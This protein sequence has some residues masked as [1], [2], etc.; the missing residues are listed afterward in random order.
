MFRRRAGSGRR[1][2]KSTSALFTACMSA[3]IVSINPRP[4]HVLEF[5]AGQPDV[6]LQAGQD[7]GD[8]C[9]RVERQRLLGAPAFLAQ[10][11][12]RGHGRRVLEVD[13]D[14]ARADHGHDPVENRLVEVDAAEPLYPLRA[15]DLLKAVLGL[16]QDRRLEGA[17][18]EVVDG[19]HGPGRHALLAG[20][21]NG[22][23]L[24]LGKQRR[25]GDARL[26]DGL[27]EEVD[28]VG[29]VAGG[30]GDD[31]GHRRFAQ[32]LGDATHDG[33]Q[34]VRHKGLC[35]VRRPT[36]DDRHRVAEPPLELARRSGRLCERATLR[37]VAGE[38][39]AVGPNDDDRR[40]GRRTLAELEDL[41]AALARG[42]SG[43][44]GR[45]Q[46]DPKRVLDRYRRRSMQVI[47]A[48]GAERLSGRIAMCRTWGRRSHLPR[49]A[50]PAGAARD[51]HVRQYVRLTGFDVPQFGH[52]ISSA[53]R[54]PV[55][56]I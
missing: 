19:D 34:L 20:V 23:R 33:P 28:L 55:R 24:R 40:N 21:L 53:M 5:L 48:V 54:W 26:A 3:Q 10:A 9:V 7:D 30:M 41:D 14:P 22:G 15:A 16:A 36:D 47:S 46:V 49:D 17:A 4:D 11:R 44:V 6:G 35:A 32:F 29:A 37:G 52:G 56:R 38:D 8:R 50:R 1:L 18:A 31:D 43:R 13:R 45:P 42:R 39:L 25:V 2:S 27:L 12:D 51:A